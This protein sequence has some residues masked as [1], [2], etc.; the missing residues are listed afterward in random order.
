MDGV[1][2]N[3]PTFIEK[4]LG[5]ASTLRKLKHASSTFGQKDLALAISSV[6]AAEITIPGEQFMQW[7]QY[8]RLRRSV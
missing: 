1:N 5:P 3:A 8:D 7:K 6:N 2:A 4:E